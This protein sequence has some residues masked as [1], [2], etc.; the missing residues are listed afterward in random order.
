M[1][2]QQSGVSTH[3]CNQDFAAIDIAVK[4]D[5]TYRMHRQTKET[6]QK[7]DSITPLPEVCHNVIF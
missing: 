1:G 6:N 5:E 4:T 7:K 3:S 2:S